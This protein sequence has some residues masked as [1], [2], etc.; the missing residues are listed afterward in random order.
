MAQA[1]EVCRLEFGVEGI[2][3]VT[4]LTHTNDALFAAVDMPSYE[5]ISYE[6]A[7]KAQI[8]AWLVKPPGFNPTKKY[9][10]LLW[11]H[12]GPQAAWPDAF[13]FRWNP[14]LFAAKGYVVLMPNP[15]GS[16]G[17]GHPFTEQ[18]SGDWAGACYE[19]LMNGVDWAIEQGFVDPNRMGAAGGSFGG[20]MVNWIL[21]HSNRFKALMSHAGVYN[22]ESMYGVTEELWFPEWDLKGTPWEDREGQYDRFSPHKFAAAFQTPTLVIHGELDFRVPI[23]EGLQ[24]FTALQRQKVPSKLLYFPD[25]GHWIQ[26][27]KNRKL[28]N[29][30]VL[31]WFDQ[32]LKRSERL[33]E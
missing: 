23:G 25:E 24:L 4:P 14:M 6:G 28:W 19:D 1:P 8:Q 20:Y 11:I 17:F 13:G 31:D 3:S 7:E 29:E 9:P 2:W 18:I 22:L 27:S 26:K 33:A 12:G 30:T 5:S 16:V 10:F 32:Y 15:H 21:G